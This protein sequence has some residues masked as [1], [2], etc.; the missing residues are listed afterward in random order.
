MPTGAPAAAPQSIA[1]P[2][3]TSTTPNTPISTE[4]TPSSVDAN[5]NLTTAEKVEVKKMLKSLKLKV[6][7]KDLDEELPFEIPDTEEAKEY[8]TRQLQMSKMGQKRAQ[9]FSQLEKEVRGFVEL[10]RKDP[11]RALSD[12]AI[13]VDIKQLAAQVIE[14]E[15]ANS[16]KSP[17]Q[18]RAEQAEA[19][20][21]DLEDERKKEKEEFDEREFTRTQ[22]AEYERYDMEM[23]QALDKSDI[24]K[25]PYYIKKMADYMLLGLQE[26]LDVRPGDVLPVVRQEFEDDV[27]EALGK[28]SEEAIERIVGKDVFNRIRKKNI[29]KVKQA[30]ATA[31]NVAKDVGKVSEPKAEIAK[32]MN[33]K[34]FFGV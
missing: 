6:D 30:P 7:G 12:P 2:T 5:P 23:T 15:I 17:E 28:M 13:G 24:P 21:K 31:K 18:L 25:S 20:L 8:M 34:D 33:F 9:D 1:A 4:T 22:E 27:K 14:Q 10:L 29:A 19:K 16:Q 3:N 11:R 32:K 26:G